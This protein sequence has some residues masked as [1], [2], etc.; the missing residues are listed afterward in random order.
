MT[1]RSLTPRPAAATT[2][3][4]QRPS[5]HFTQE[6]ARDASSQ[7]TSSVLLPDGSILTALGTGYRAIVPEDE[8]QK[9]R[10]RDVGLVNWRVNNE[11]LND[12]RTIA[13]APADSDLRN[14]L[15][16]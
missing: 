9:F 3:T 15:V 12:D 1:T 2:T 14:R 11:G 5:T 8:P 16:P 7:A 13:N 4:Q 6:D 10:P